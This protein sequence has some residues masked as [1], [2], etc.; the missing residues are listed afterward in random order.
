MEVSCATSPSRRRWR[1][2]RGEYIEFNAFG[3]RRDCR[4]DLKEYTTE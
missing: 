2:L 4:G 3:T 1:G